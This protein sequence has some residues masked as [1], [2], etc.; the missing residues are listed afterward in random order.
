M[1]TNGLLYALRKGKFTHS[2]GFP[3]IKVT[4][5]DFIGMIYA[6]YDNFQLTLTIQ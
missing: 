4:V 5:I 6:F 1:S 3:V 2:G